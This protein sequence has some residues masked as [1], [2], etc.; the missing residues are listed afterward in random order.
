MLNDVILINSLIF[1]C[2]EV[3]LNYILFLCKIKNIESREQIE[4]AYILE[5]Q[6]T[7]LK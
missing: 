1:S 6:Y 2:K 5:R 4:A 3:K 7:R